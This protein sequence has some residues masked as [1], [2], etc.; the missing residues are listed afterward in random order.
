MRAKSRE[1]KAVLRTDFLWFAG[2]LML[3]C[4][5]LVTS[6]FYFNVTGR[7]DEE[8]AWLE[9]YSQSFL[10]DL[11]LGD[12]ASVE[13]KIK[14]FAQRH[15]FKRVEIA[16]GRNSINA[17]GAS[18]QEP[19][20]FEQPFL[21]LYSRL[22]GAP[23]ISVDL[24]DPVG[25]LF[26]TMTV[27]YNPHAF[28][29]SGISS[30]LVIAVTFISLL[31]VI[32]GLYVRRLSE[33]EEPFLSLTDAI[34][35]M[36]RVAEGTTDMIE[37]RLE[38]A[39][40]RTG[41]SE[42]DLLQKEFSLSL[43]STVRLQ[44]E[45]NSAKVTAAIARTTQALAHDVRKPFSMLKSII[46]SIEV[47]ED[48]MIAQRIMRASLPEVSQAMVSVE[49]MI[50]DVMQIGSETAPFQEEAC[51]ESLIEGSIGEL[52]RVYTDADISISYDLYHKHM[53]LVDTVRVGR[54]FSN[55]LGNALQA[56]GYKGS[57][58]IK[59]REVT[60]F[61]EFTVGNSGS[62]I[63]PDDR[64]KLFD[65]FF[66]SG[67]KGGT[68]LG[69]AIAKKIVEAHGGTIF[70]HSELNV[71]IPEGKVEF[72][73][74]L[75]STNSLTTSR[76]DSLPVSSHEVYATLQAARSVVR[77][78]DPMDS[79]ES[80]LEREILRRLHVLNSKPN[81]LLLDDEPVYRN[82]LVSHLKKSPALADAIDV[83]SAKN[84]AEAIANASRVAPVLMITDVDL[85]PGSANGIDVVKQLRASGFHGQ[86]CI[87]SNRFLFDDNKIAMGAGVNSVLLK[88]MSRIHLLTLVLA[89]LPE[90]P[91]GI[92]LQKSSKPTFAYVDD[93]LIFLLG[94]RIKVKE[95]AV[96]HEFQSS[97]KFFERVKTEA[98]FLQSLDFIVTDFY[99]SASDKLDGLSFAAEIRSIG[100]QNPI[101]LASDAEID[102]TQLIAAGI[103]GVI[104]KTILG[105][106]EL[107]KRVANCKQIFRPSERT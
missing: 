37:S 56:I 33:I 16:F 14:R 54:V 27:S 78:S 73:F 7:L 79:R 76:T 70:C 68:G 36:K 1:L 12:V 19:T 96:C 43:G 107:E 34:R 64:H 105:W 72:V 45:V 55:I 62:Y 93:S 51:P 77:I 2:L 102:E 94:M 89:S 69:L 84:D 47:A 82:S 46:Q 35:Q 104:S 42:M 32:I 60:N 97:V 40:V 30:A 66:T 39:L 106:E 83:F 71:A 13:A 50:E 11:Q 26:G 98:A 85:G 18:A 80:D 31:L 6:F 49:G 38:D 99:F 88:P 48:P 90:E 57:L 100:Y 52:F 41:I 58:W 103:N 95:K 74:T 25:T 92:A 29:R 75:P 24:K 3:I 61:V 87:H 4:G 15:D 86:I 59:T 20:F 44:E 91:I 9:S 81:I 63:L 10:K 5:V 67:K 53:V 17:E 22:S 21:I 23:E 28:Y 101:I 65:A 8:R